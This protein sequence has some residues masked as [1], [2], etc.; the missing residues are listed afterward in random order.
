MMS[1]VCGSAESADTGRHCDLRDP[2]VANVNV[3]I[4]RP[5]GS[6]GDKE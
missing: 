5:Y 2:D 4:L 3:G 6:V 1:I